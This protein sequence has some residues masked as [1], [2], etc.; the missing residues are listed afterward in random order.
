MDPILEKK[1]ADQ[2]KYYSDVLKKGRD[3][4]KVK[5]ARSVSDF[6]KAPSRFQVSFS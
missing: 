5:R 6:R 3:G 2:S 1:R 4:Y